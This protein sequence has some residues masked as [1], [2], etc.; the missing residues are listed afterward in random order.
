MHFPPC[1]F[2]VMQRRQLEKRDT[3]GDFW[4]RRLHDMALRDDPVEERAEAFGATKTTRE[5]EGTTTRRPEG[6]ASET[7][8]GESARKG[9][10]TAGAAADKKK[11]KVGRRGGKDRKRESKN[12]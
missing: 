11:T 7:G 1:A 4:A 3:L 2:Q 9:E 8:E 6:N 12:L 5:A 10:G